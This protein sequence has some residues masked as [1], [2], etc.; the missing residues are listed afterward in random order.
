M[1]FA[2]IWRGK[3]REPQQIVYLKSDPHSPNEFRANGS[4]RNMMPFYEAFGV[5][6][7]DKMYL[8]PEKR[9]SIW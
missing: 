7:G 5:K 8:P 1:G 9:V 3:I 4:L 2:Q 6:V